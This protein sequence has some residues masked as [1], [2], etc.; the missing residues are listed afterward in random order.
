MPSDIVLLST[1]D[2][3]NPYWTNK[4]HVAT[5]LARRGHRVLYI[6]SLGLRR[7]TTSKRDFVRVLSRLGRGMRSAHQVGPN[8]WLWSPLVIPFHGNSAAR[9]INRLLFSL[10]LHLTVRRV[11][12]DKDI[13][14]T[15]NPTTLS[16][17]SRK[18]F[19]TLVYHAVDDIASQ[20]G[21]SSEYITAEDRRL[22]LEADIIF[23]TSRK[24]FDDHRAINA[25]TY[26]YPN[27]ADYDHFATALSD[28]SA[29]PADISHLRAP[30]IGFVGAI[31]DYKINVELI[32][33]VA[34]SRPEWTFLFIGEVGEGEPETDV[35]KL[36][37]CPNIHL[38]GG[39]PYETLPSY[40]KAFDV[41][42]L[43]SRLNSYT[44]SMFP[45]KF[46][47]YLAA[48][49]RIVATDLPAL[50][51]FVS[52]FHVADNAEAFTSAISEVLSSPDIGRPM[53]LS[54]ARVNT[55]E[56]RTASMMEEVNRIMKGPQF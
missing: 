22:S 8:I 37:S 55:Y 15:Y 48:G 11:G 26:Y 5:E 20:P 21:M 46:F 51:P 41:A 23:A 12:L 6:D 40:L 47:E 27:V 28:E 13:L 9:A 19:R 54:V 56:T 34:I 49:R 7:P 18:K 53:R 36:L 43:P 38:I 31:A 25:R 4:Q 50:R 14:W 39:R 30:I 10:G 35:S 45:M 52:L 33:Q 44:A 42:I 32:T 1:A 16:F 24:L 29:V 17:V 3:S 2:W